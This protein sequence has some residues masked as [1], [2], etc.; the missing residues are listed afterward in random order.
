MSE[1]R[2]THMDR[3]DSKRQTNGG[4]I[5]KKKKKKEWDKNSAC[6]ISKRNSE[7]E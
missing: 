4:K 3:V 1:N 6:K 7:K 5:Q 2:K